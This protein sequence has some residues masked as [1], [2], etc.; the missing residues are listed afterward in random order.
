MAP[1]LLHVTTNSS[2]MHHD[3]VP[4]IGKLNHYNC[5]LLW[6]F[7]ASLALIQQASDQKHSNHDRSIFFFNY[8]TASAILKHGD[9]RLLLGD[10]TA[11][12]WMLWFLPLYIINNGFCLLVFS[13]KWCYDTVKRVY[14]TSSSNVSFSKIVE[15]T[16]IVL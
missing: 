3:M 13:E 10:H 6:M 16:I 11:P 14:S 12:E 5:L 9:S 2:E 7:S 1:M 8:N 4:T 15:Y